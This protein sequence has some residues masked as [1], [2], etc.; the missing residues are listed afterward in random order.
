VQ[1]CPQYGGQASGLGFNPPAVGLQNFD[2]RASEFCKD[3]HWP[4]KVGTAL[5][6]A[7]PTMHPTGMSTSVPF[8]ELSRRDFLCRS[9]LAASTLA[10]SPAGTVAAFGAQSVS[11]PIVVFTKVYQT[12]NLNYDDAAAVT[13]E[14]GLDGIDCPV[15]PGG[16]VSPE[17]VV[18]DLPRYVEALRR[19]NLQMPLLT[20]AIT[21]PSSPHAETVLRVAKKLGVQFYRLGFI[22]RQ[23]DLPSQVREIRAQLKDLAAFNKE[24]GLGALL[25]NHSPAGHTYFGGDLSELEQAVEGFEPAQIGVAFDIG[26]ALVV[27]GDAWRA[28]FAKLKSQFKIAYVKD[29]KRSGGWVPFGAGDIGGT[30]YFELLRQMNYQAP[31]SLHIEF[32]WTDEGKSKNRTA[33]VKAL[34]DSSRILRQWL[35]A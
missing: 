10:L 14:A 2:A 4:G 34:K 26:H 6:A 19:D 20:T 33:L 9:A 31:I 1:D 11:G 16:E 25:Q 18:D 5:E 15:R 12:L 3:T 8:T 17:R 32:D 21:S 13:A 7:N 22:D 35:S 27:H 30:G 24:I 29:V 28:H 23:K